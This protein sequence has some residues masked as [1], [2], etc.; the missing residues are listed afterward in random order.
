MV[1][2]GKLLG[3]SA[4]RRQ[5]RNCLLNTTRRSSVEP[6]GVQTKLSEVD[7]PDRYIFR[8]VALALDALFHEDRLEY[9]A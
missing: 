9:L 2:L 7:D 4:R 8:I 5:Q 6:P 3:K 1:I